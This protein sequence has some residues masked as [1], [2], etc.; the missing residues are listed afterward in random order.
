MSVQDTINIEEMQLDEEIN[1]YLTIALAN[2]FSKGT[3]NVSAKDMVKLKGLLAHY[4]KKKHPFTACF[5]DQ[6][7]HGLSKE[8]AAKRCA[9]LKDLI[10][11][12]T[13]WRGKKKN[14]SE[15]EL[16]EFILDDYPDNNYI[17]QFI[18]WAVNLDDETVNMMLITNND[19]ESENMT[20][21]ELDAG[22]IAW[23]NS[24]SW[25]DI[26][27]KIEAALND[28]MGGDS[29]GMSYWVE[30]VKGEEALVA[31][32]N[33]HLIVPFSITKK[34]MVEVSDEEDW[35]M[36]EKGFIESDLKMSDDNKE[37]LAELFFA[38]KKESES[39]ADSDGLIWKT[40]LREGS[41]KYSPGSDGKANSKS[42]TI[43]KSGTSDPKKLI[44]SMADIKKNFEVGTVQHV[45]V[46]LN[47]DNKVQE[48]T[49]FVKKLRY[50]KDE[51]G[52]ATLEAAIDFT[53]LDIK[54]KI[55]RG[56]IP[57]V[58]GG[59]HMN[60]IDKETGKK[61]NSVLGHVCLTPTPWIKG[62]KPFGVQTS[63][64]L[65]V[66]GFS[67]EQQTSQTESEGGI[68]EMTTVEIESV[69]TFLEKIGLSEDEVETRLARYNELEQESKKNRIDQKVREWEEKKKTPALVTA[70][71]AIL[72]ADEGTVVLNLSEEGKEVSL[73]ASDIVDRLVA[74]APNVALADDPI[75]D[76]AAEGTAPPDD[77]TEENLSDEVK[78]EARHLFLRERFSEEDAIAEAIRRDK[79]TN[80]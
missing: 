34:G 21:L 15:E 41:W 80:A 49:G 58:S 11:G 46:P 45:T 71:K 74:A 29:Y 70:A 18:D 2:G 31:H 76:E 52:R 10:V 22:D 13:K 64:N 32:A 57:N 30:D 12:N 28:D 1:D 6:T 72:M 73:T 36:V 3:A 42:L 9:V 68:E 48:N 78:A 19:D 66:V 8:H 24:G 53:E 69:D 5:H 27:G 47:H 79:E 59:I 61:F 38:D 65:T 44:I 35:K 56:T 23:T 33:S 51:K 77:A 25:N 62:M 54:E 50:G 40:F 39:I 20:E 14:L 26:R 55:E 67:E 7:K 63:E 37:F 60:Y 16:A 17:L 4:A 43:V 75:T